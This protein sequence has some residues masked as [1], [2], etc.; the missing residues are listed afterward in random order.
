GEGFLELHHGDRKV[1]H[2]K[3]TSYERGVQYG[4]LVGDEIEGVLHK[5]P[6]YIAAQGSTLASSLQAIITPVGSLAFRPYFDADARDELRGIVDGM[7]LRNPSTFVQEQDLIFMNALIDL[8][9]VVDL[10]V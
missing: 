2:T 5:L 10:D 6:A 7:R 4:V 8:G 9:A 1:L 3:G